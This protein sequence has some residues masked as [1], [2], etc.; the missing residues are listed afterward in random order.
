MQQTSEA[1]NIIRW[2]YFAGALRLKV[3]FLFESLSECDTFLVKNKN[4]ES[5]FYRHVFFCNSDMNKIN[6]IKMKL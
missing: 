2:Q 6:K 5:V 3:E 1:G 4:T